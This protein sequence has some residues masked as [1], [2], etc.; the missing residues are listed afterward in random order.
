MRPPHVRPIALATALAT[1]LAALPAGGACASRPN[2]QVNTTVTP[3]ARFGRY[4]TF[5]ILTPRRTGAN[6][7]AADDPMVE[8][9]IINRAL[10]DSLR[11]A[12]EARGYRPGGPDADLAVAYYAAARQALDVT[13]VDYG[14]PYRA[15]WWSDRTREEIRPI[16]QGTV[17]V[18]VIDRRSDRLVWRDTGRTEVSDDQRQ[19]TSQLGRAVDEIVRKLPKPS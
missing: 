2:V 14:Y 11:R 9:S 6:P 1:A 13:T 5:T 19:Y 16:T 7:A 3:E 8:N 18:D 17:V 12:L 15:W 10:R 4:R